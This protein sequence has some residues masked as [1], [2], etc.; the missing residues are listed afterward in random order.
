MCVYTSVLASTG[1]LENE[2]SEVEHPH[3]NVTEP[4]RYGAKNLR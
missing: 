2:E 3:S 1:Q 4:L